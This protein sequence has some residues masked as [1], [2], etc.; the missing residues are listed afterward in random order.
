MTSL[1][2]I[3]LADHVVLLVDPARPIGRSRFTSSFLFSED[4]APPHA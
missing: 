4:A 2:G 1:Q 3:G